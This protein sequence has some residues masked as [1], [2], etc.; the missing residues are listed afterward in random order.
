VHVSCKIV[1]IP[2]P[3]D[4]AQPPSAAEHAQ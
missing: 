1:H 3:R 4:G 2:I